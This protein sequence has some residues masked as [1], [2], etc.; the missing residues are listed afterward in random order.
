VHKGFG[1][2]DLIEKGHMDDLGIDR[3]I[4]LKGIF[5]KRVGKARTGLIWFSIETG[6][7]RL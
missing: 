1:W 2:R 4:I 5:K 3:R 7:K 6:G